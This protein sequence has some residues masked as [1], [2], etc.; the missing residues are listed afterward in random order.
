M[1]LAGDGKYITKPGVGELRKLF[2]CEGCF[3]GLLNFG[4]TVL[5]VE[6]FDTSRRVNKFLF[7]GIEGVAV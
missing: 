7:P 4:F 6:L 3:F 2:G 1:R 5:S